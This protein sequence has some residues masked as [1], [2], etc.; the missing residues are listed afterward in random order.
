MGW[1]WR[2]TRRN[3]M[4]ML[5]DVFHHRWRLRGGKNKTKKTKQ[6][7]R[8]PVHPL[9]VRVSGRE[10]HESSEEVTKCTRQQVPDPMDSRGG[11]KTCKAEFCLYGVICKKWGY[12]IWFQRKG[13]TLVFFITL[14]EGA[15]KARICGD[16]NHVL[17]D[18]AWGRPSSFAP[19][20]A[21]ILLQAFQIEF[22]IPGNQ[23]VYRNY[24]LIE[25]GITLFCD[26]CIGWFFNIWGT[27][28]SCK[29]NEAQ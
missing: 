9:A 27:R 23:W 17:C 14:Q 13:K 7:I 11:R 20:E 6:K 24:C 19:R 16:I 3:E 1:T 12:S 2:G 21:F 25:V 5:P 8:T 18:D 28:W 4:N 26:L 22:E 10:K 15:E 29:P